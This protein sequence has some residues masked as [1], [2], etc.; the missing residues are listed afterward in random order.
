MFLFYLIKCNVRTDTLSV[1]YCPRTLALDTSL[2]RRFIFITFPF[3]SAVN[4]L[5]NQFYFMVAAQLLPVVHS[6]DRVTD[7]S[8]YIQTQAYR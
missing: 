3:L 8:V 7:Y 4:Y 6:F 5:C 1:R 2:L